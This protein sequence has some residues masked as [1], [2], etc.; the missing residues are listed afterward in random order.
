MGVENHLLRTG[1]RKPFLGV[2]HRPSSATRATSGRLGQC[3]GPGAD[4]P[5]GPVFLV[6]GAGVSVLPVMISVEFEGNPRQAGNFQRLKHHRPRK[7]GFL[8]H[9]KT[10]SWIESIDG[11]PDYVFPIQEAPLSWGWV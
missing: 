7:P 11:T 4:S 1:R 9:L 2:V 6:D 8:K 5:R 10:I 3:G